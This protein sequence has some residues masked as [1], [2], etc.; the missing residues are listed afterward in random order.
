M[1]NDGVI[2]QLSSPDVLYERPDNSFVAQ[3]IGENNKLIGTVTSES[4]GICQVSIPDAGSVK[5]KSINTSG[6]GSKTLL[7]IRPERV[8]INP[9]KTTGL[10]VLKGKIEE[11][12]YLGDHIR[13]RMQ[14]AG[15][16]DFIVKI[17][18]KHGHEILSEG[19]TARIAWKA[20]DCRALD[21][22]A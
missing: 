20:E 5:A 7:S 6:K 19:E 2:Q 18:N 11:L 9:K 3:F 10:N 1:F 17:P 15:H 21:Y 12:I 14:V 16:D 4:K 13:T 22:V 8:Q